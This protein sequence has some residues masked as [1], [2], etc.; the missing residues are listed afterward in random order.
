[1]LID[2]FFAP[3]GGRLVDPAHA[4]GRQLVG[5]IKAWRRGH[6]PGLFQR[7]LNYLEHD[8]PWRHGDLPES[9]QGHG[10]RVVA[11][12]PNAFVYFLTTDE[13]VDLEW[14]DAHWPGLVEGLSRAPGVGLV[15]ARSAGG[16]V[17]AVQGK[18]S[19]VDGEPLPLL[20]GRPDEEVV[21]AGLR[22]LMA[23]RCAGDLVIY[24]NESPQGNVSYV[25]EHG[26]HAGPSEDEMET[27]VV[28][29]PGVDLPAPLTHPTQLYP[30]FR[31]YRAA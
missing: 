4:E 21:R 28:A 2:D 13:P 9:R 5:G 26:A 27:F 25:H 16:P 20:G 10:V 22:E 19:R 7:F 11:A 29:P 17:C 15:L 14:I 6:T 23:M 1:V 12:G 24:G 31:A 30:H 18:R 8:F 3:L